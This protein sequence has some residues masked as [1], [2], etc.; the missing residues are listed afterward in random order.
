MK[1]LH[2]ALF[3]SSKPVTNF[4]Y[5]RDIDPSTIHLND[6]AFMERT[7]YITVSGK[8]LFKY[9]GGELLACSI[10]LMGQSV[11]PPFAKSTITL[12]SIPSF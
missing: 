5:T 8:A 3:F 10:N 4:F 11:D 2:Y 1:I 9:I 6:Y 7:M 12:E